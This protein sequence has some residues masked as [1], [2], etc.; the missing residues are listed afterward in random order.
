MK[1][2][3]RNLTAS[4]VILPQGLNS[5][6]LPAGAD[7]DFLYSSLV[8][9]DINKLSTL[10]KS[11]SISF[12][13]SAGLGIPAGLPVNPQTTYVLNDQ[14]PDG[15]TAGAPGYWSINDNQVRVLNGLTWNTIG[16]DQWLEAAPLSEVRLA[17]G[18]VKLL[19]GRVLQIGGNDRVGSL[20]T[21]A[22]ATCQVYDPATG[23]WSLVD[24][25][26]SPFGAL[27]AVTLPNGKVLT[28]GGIVAPALAA[29][30]TNRSFL[31]DPA[32]VAGSQWTEVGNLPA[33]R[34][35][36]YGNMSMFVSTDG[37]EVFV[38]GGTEDAV[39]TASAHAAIYNIAAGTWAA[40]PAAP[41]GFT[42]AG[43]AQATNGDVL[44]V[45]G[46]T[47]SGLVG[48]NASNK[49]Y[50]YAQSAG[51]FTGGAWSTLDT[52]PSVP[53]EDAPGSPIP[54]C[55]ATPA[56]QPIGS[57]LYV[58]GGLIQDHVSQDQN[59]SSSLIVD[60]AAAPGSQIVLGPKMKMKRDNAK[61]CLLDDGRVLVTSGRTPSD[62]TEG[63]DPSQKAFKFSAKMGLFFLIGTPQRLIKLDDGSVI[64]AGC[65]FIEPNVART[66]RTFLF[67]PGR[68]PTFGAAY[69]NDD[70]PVPPTPID[71]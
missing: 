8:Q 33:M 43:T 4:T 44:Y 34:A 62:K 53:G 9:G 6:P 61:F 37:T 65:I 17:G 25:L 66:A 35:N 13:G 55:R 15:V 63:L 2:V 48:F 16:C 70:A 40:A 12:P 30:P 41:G 54:G 1:T 7:Q 20:G 59:R 71:Q 26:P 27:W 21:V 56:C 18:L 38:A 29:A 64:V 49:I 69:G 50:K 57:K 46:Y 11:G 14:E 60:P 19:D 3:V 28:A 24:P 47:G 5:F 36:P 45:G 51:K 32:A 23:A 67:I 31:F 52:M 39:A 42:T 58:F 68:L 22:F 10:A